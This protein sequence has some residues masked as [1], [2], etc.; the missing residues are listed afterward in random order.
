MLK[1][2]SKQSGVVDRTSSEHFYSADPSQSSPL[3]M[4]KNRELRK[5]KTSHSNVINSESEKGLSDETLQSL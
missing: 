1:I 4:T 5:I 2:T 3:K